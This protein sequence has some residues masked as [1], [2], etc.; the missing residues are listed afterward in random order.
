MK[1][2]NN[3]IDLN[4]YFIN[5][6]SKKYNINRDKFFITSYICYDGFINYHYSYSGTTTN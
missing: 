5:I 3:E 6:L 2:I 4:E 1:N